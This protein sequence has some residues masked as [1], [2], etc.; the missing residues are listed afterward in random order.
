M[1]KKIELKLYIYIYTR[2]LLVIDSETNLQSRQKHRFPK[3]ESRIDTF[4]LTSL[5]DNIDI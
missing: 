4:V 3:K 5:G 1:N 2:K